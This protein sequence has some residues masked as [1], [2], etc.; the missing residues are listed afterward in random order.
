LEREGVGIELSRASYES[1]DWADA[2]QTAWEKGREA[3]MR[4]RRDVDTG[5]RH[6]EV[7]MM[8]QEVVDWVNGWKQSTTQVIIP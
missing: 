8:A 5:T 6:L 1:G 7:K 4:R 3:K 2:I